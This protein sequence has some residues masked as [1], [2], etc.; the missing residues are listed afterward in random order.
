MADI[1]QTIAGL[2]SGAT[3]T[4]SFWQAGSEEY[5]RGGGQSE[6]FVASL[7]DQSFTSS[8]MN[9]SNQGFAPWNEFSTT[10]TWDGVGNVLQIA[11][12]G[13]GDPAFPLLADASLTGTAVPESSTW[14]MIV[15]GF[16]GM[17]LLARTRRKAIGVA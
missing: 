7:G 11:A 12:V 13:S 8:T 9:I 2:V 17:G 16:A 5:T 10:F 14:A 3:Y 15:A 1:E 6:N 4:L